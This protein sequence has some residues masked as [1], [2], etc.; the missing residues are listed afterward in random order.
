LDNVKV[1]VANVLGPVGQGH[2]VAFN[3]LN[4]GRLKLGLNAVGLAKQALGLSLGYAKQR[5]AFGKP[6][7]EFGLIR[8]KLAEMAARIYAAESMNWRVAG[9]IEAAGAGREARAAEEFAAECSY[10][11]V[12]A[13]EAVGYAVD[14]GVQIHGGYGFHH[15]YPIERIYRDARI[16][17][18]FEGTNEIN[19]MAATR[20]LLK[21]VKDVRLRL[22]GGS[23]SPLKRLTLAAFAAAQAKFGA[24]IDGEQE[25]LAALTDLS[26]AAF[27]LETSELRARKTK[28]ALAQSYATL[29]GATLTEGAIAAAR[30]LFVA[31]GAAMPVVE[32]PAV[33]AFE[34]RRQIAGRLLSAGR[35]LA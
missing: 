30:P 16:Q 4:I 3:I 6:I 24:A 10:V 35:F 15:D 20:M 34:L 8:H 23:A 33:D 1:P 32:V 9:L 26:I 19:R 21:R 25:V 14:E 22:E 12:Y 7:G 13:S 2:K 29:L 28:S 5:V 17:R 27:A 31:A 11:K 18:I